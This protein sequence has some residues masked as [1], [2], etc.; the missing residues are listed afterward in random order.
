MSVPSV[1]RF[2]LVSCPCLVLPLPGTGNLRK[3][4]TLSALVWSDVSVL[5]VYLFGLVCRLFSLQKPQAAFSFHL[6]R[7]GNCSYEKCIPNAQS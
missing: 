3:R 1:S 5:P 7:T 4:P 6:N 2:G